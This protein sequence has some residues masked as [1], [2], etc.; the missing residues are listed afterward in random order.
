MLQD[1]Y[2]SQMSMYLLQI[3]WKKEKE[4]DE[5]VYDSKKR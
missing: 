3:A 1:I 5:V 4:T 2:S